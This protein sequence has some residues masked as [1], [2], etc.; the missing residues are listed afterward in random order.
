MSQSTNRLLYA[1]EAL[2][3][4]IAEF[5]DAQEAISDDEFTQDL[6]SVLVCSYEPLLEKSRFTLLGTVDHVAR[7][8][9]GSL[10]DPENLPFR[11]CFAQAIQRRAII[12]G[13]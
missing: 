2:N 4:A 11:L 10:A 8:L 5:R 9:E 6:P 3:A 1:F 13:R 7:T 12:Q